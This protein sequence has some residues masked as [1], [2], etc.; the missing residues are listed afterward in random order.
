MKDMSHAHRGYYII[1]IQENYITKKMS[2]KS[3]YM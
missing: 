3:T 2:G 1:A